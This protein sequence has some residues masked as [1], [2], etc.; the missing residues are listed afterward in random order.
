ML[1]NVKYLAHKI[2]LQVRMYLAVVNELRLLCLVIYE[3][4][5]KGIMLWEQLHR[6]L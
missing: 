1:E 2:T 3:S 5:I 6:Y 4:L